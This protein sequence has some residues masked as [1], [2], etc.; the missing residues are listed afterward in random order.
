[1]TT[2]EPTIQRRKQPIFVLTTLAVGLFFLPASPSFAQEFDSP[3]LI[4]AAAEGQTFR[5]RN[6]LDAGANIDTTGSF[7]E[8]ALM[9]AAL[10]G[11][12]EI[13]RLLIERGANTDLT[14]EDGDGALIYAVLYGNVNTSVALLEHGADVNFIST[15]GFKPIHFAVRSRSIPL[16]DTLL[17]FGAEIDAA[18][19]DGTQPLH[20]AI[21]T[22]DPGLMNHLLEKGAN[23]NAHGRNGWTPWMFAV[24]RFD[25]TLAAE[26]EARGA[27]ARTSLRTAIEEMIMAIGWI[28]GGRIEIGLSVLDELPGIDPQ[29]AIPGSVWNMV[30]WTGTIHGKPSLVE[31][32]CEEATAADPTDTNAIDSRAINR[33]ALGNLEGALLDFQV[34]VQNDNTPR[35]DIRLRE[36]WIRTLERGENP[37]TPQVLERLRFPWLEGSFVETTRDLGVDL[38][39]MV[40]TTNSLPDSAIIGGEGPVGT[41]GFSRNFHAAQET[42]AYGNSRFRAVSFIA[43]IFPSPETAI[44]TV[45]E[46]ND[47]ALVPIARSL[48]EDVVGA[49]GATVDTFQARFEPLPEI[50]E[51]Q[52]IIAI[53]VTARR[54]QDL[55]I[56]DDE[57]DPEL[58]RE[59]D[60][61]E[62]F[63]LYVALISRGRAVGLVMAISPEEQAHT[64]DIVEMI[65]IAER[66]IMEQLPDSSGAN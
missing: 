63:E 28:N 13:V 40:P 5:V 24:A 26:L 29:L 9:M 27:D 61:V 44:S 49:S 17:S 22:G 32:S 45:T 48:V 64:E 33:A 31:Q 36:R 41:N 11:H 46:I 37:I 6:L 20:E 53:N 18:A 42:F 60:T 66:A 47:Q 14:D 54:S 8:T 23:V 4:E 35:E 58:A 25:S 39:A 16:I 57:P 62:T 43:M 55:Q 51:P 19:D 34:V 38:I 2:P 65:R 15:D 1:M 7:G 3:P 59:N 56:D 30:C 52:K 50:D 10:E 21:D 12:E